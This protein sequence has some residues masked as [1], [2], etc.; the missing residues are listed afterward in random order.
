MSV[1]KRKLQRAKDPENKTRPNICGNHNQN[2]LL[3][4]QSFIRVRVTYASDLSNGSNNVILP[5][6]SSGDNLHTDYAR[7]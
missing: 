7:R 3:I 4:H 5:K 2:L 6:T 1:V